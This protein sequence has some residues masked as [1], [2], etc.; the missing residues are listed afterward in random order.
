ML[1]TSVVGPWRLPEFAGLMAQL[2][3]GDQNYPAHGALEP[4]VDVPFVD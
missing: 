2:A 3:P 1:L 4:G